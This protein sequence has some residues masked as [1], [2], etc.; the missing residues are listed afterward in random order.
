[1]KDWVDF[2][3]KGEPC[4]NWGIDLRVNKVFEEDNRVISENKRTSAFFVGQ[5][6]QILLLGFQCRLRVEKG[7]IGKSN[8]LDARGLTSRVQDN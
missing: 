7:M 3:M 8:P 4:S 1:M 2:E 5:W 6:G